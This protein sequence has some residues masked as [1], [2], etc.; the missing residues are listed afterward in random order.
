MAEETKTRKPR[1]NRVYGLALT[2]RIL[3]PVD[4]KDLKSQI[5]VSEAAMEAQKN[6]DFSGLLSLPGARIA[7]AGRNGGVLFGAL[8]S[9]EEAAK[10]EEGGQTDIEE[11]ISET[12]VGEDGSDQTEASEEPSEG[13][14]AGRGRGRRAA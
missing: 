10:A 9:A 8:P 2:V 3:V 4:R 13:T 12:E 7:P 1:T 6:N 14:T 5:A 11:A